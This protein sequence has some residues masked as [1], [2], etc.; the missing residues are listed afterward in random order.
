MKDVFVSFGSNIKEKLTS[1][2]FG[3]FFF[4]LLFDNKEELFDLYRWNHNKDLMYLIFHNWI[5]KFDASYI[6]WLVIHTGFI[7]LGTQIISVLS[8]VVVKFFQ[9]TA[10]PFLL[11]FVYPKGVVL[12]SEIERLE[13]SNTRF[14]EEV[15]SLKLRNNQL[16]ERNTELVNEV[17]DAGTITTEKVANHIK[18]IDNEALDKKV[19]SDIKKIENFESD[20]DKKFY[21]K[22]KTDFANKA[23][24]R[25]AKEEIKKYEESNK[26]DDLYDLLENSS[27]ERSISGSKYEAFKKSNSFKF[28][29]MYSFGQTVRLEEQGVILQK[30]LF[31]KFGLVSPKHK[32]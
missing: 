22:S 30:I 2:F 25:Q 13:K 11:Q 16:E 1:P 17:K 27:L 12:A 3:I 19:K 28:G 29:E 4:V 24:I 5:E 31:E 9:E 32:K 14:Q 8:K 20:P 10:L 21:I 15:E 7:L 26:I 23:L 18:K 6:F